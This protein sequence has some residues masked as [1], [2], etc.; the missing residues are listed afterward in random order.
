[1]T[2]DK[3]IAGK[4]YVGTGGDVALYTLRADG[5]F[6]GASVGTD[7][8]AY[9][10]Y[11]TLTGWKATSSR[12]TVGCQ[13]TTD[14]YI[15][16]SE[17]WQLYGEGTQYSRRS[18][19]ALVDQIIDNNKLIIANNLLCARYA[20]KLTPEQ[21]NAVRGLQQRLEE[22]NSAL[23][24]AGVCEKLEQSYPAGYAELQ[25]YLDRLMNNTGVG[26]VT[27]TIIVTAIVIA[28]LSTAAYFAYKAYAA[29]S[30][31]DVKYS[32]ELTKILTEKLT[33]EEYQ[34]L[35]TETKGIVTKARIKQS[36]GT[37]GKVG[38]MALCAVGG[39]FL[40]KLLQQNG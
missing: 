1:M 13:T 11:V 25:P 28:S 27:V 34:Q 5:A 7:L 35:L 16:M 19:Q 39:Y 40:Y 12:G 33:E 17:G 10:V 31:Q 2:F 15:I 37:Y 30:E 24:D 21:R 3:T 20:E 22:R 9:G 14:D 32:K 26:S 36:L 38:V 6:A 4:V 18:A 8:G 23:I 29:Q